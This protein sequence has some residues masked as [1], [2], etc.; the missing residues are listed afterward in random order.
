MFPSE[1]F[2]GIEINTGLLVFSTNQQFL[3]SSDDTVLNPDTA[4]LRSMSTFNYNKTI[5]PISLGTTV[6]YIDN[7]GKFSRFNEMANVQR[8]GE[9]NVVEVSKNCTYIITKRYRLTD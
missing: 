6:A 8:E 2:D 3:L 9:P 5:P 1:L 7:S 4:K